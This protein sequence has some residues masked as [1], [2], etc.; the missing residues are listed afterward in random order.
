MEEKHYLSS[1]EFSAHGG[2]F[3]LILKGTGPVGTITVSGLPQEEDH[4][5]VVETVRAF[6]ATRRDAGPGSRS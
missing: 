2:A 4:A 1:M 6:L 5:L 3:P